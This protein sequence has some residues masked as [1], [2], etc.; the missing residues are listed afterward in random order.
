ML[1]WLLTSCFQLYW[2]PSI[3]K[4]KSEENQ[5]KR[6][7][8]KGEKREGVILCPQDLLLGLGISRQ[9]QFCAGIYSSFMFFAFIGTQNTRSNLSFLVFLLYRCF[10]RIFQRL[11]SLQSYLYLVIWPCQ[12]L[13]CVLLISRLHI[14]THVM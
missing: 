11:H 9:K 13:L 8:M 14:F 4:V 3:L 10:S 6:I 7:S 12:L 2:Y 5:I 1:F